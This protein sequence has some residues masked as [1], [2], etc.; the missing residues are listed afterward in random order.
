MAIVNRNRVR[1]ADEPD[2]IWYVSK[3]FRDFL[4]V[5]QGFRAKSVRAR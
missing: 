1:V 2:I 3:H 5:G 4:D